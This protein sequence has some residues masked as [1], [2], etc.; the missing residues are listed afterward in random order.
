MGTAVKDLA[1][2]KEMMKKY[3]KHMSLA[4]ECMSMYERRHLREIGTLEQDIA[5]GLDDETHKVDSKHVN[6][7]LLKVAA[8]PNILALERIRLIMLYYSVW[9][10]IPDQIKDELQRG[11]SPSVENAVR[12]IAKVGVDLNKPPPTKLALSKERADALMARNKNS[13]LLL[14]RYLPVLQTIMEHLVNYT[15]N[16]DDFPYVTPPPEEQ[17]SQMQ[18]KQGRSARRKGPADWKKDEK[19]VDREE[20]RK[21]R[22]I[23]FVI[24]GMTYS[25][26]RAAYEVSDLCKSNVFIGSTSTL[27]VK[28]FI[29]GLGSMGRME[30]VRIMCESN[31][32]DEWED[33]LHRL[34]VEERERR[35]AE[36]A[37]K[38]AAEAPAKGPAV[39][40]T[41]GAVAV[42][43]PRPTGIAFCW[44]WTK[45]EVSCTQDGYI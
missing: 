3:E 9:G 39:P 35:E 43:K 19:A 21:P 32:G 37:A 25:E 29:Q 8:D 36:I 40:T 16:E 41:N 17:R 18:Q 33:E 24:G 6:E 28:D 14:M 2:Y 11:T 22:T 45:G 15:L 10:A 4:Q 12:G 34:Q 20:D 31:A 7:G 13:Q 23:V 42:A 5:T 26:M 30:F 38:T 44:A 1:M 27:T